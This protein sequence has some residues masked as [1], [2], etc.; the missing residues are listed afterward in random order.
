MN[1]CS[2]I[3]RNP[4]DWMMNPYSFIPKNPKSQKMNPCSFIPK[5][6]KSRMMNPCSFIPRKPGIIRIYG[7]DHR[8]DQRPRKNPNI[9]SFEISSG[10]STPI[11]PIYRILVDLD[12]HHVSLK[13]DHPYSFGTPPSYHK[14]L[15]DDLGLIHRV[16]Q[17]FTYQDFTTSEDDRS[18]P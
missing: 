7:P 3:P 10:V 9:L 6:P 8:L 12:L 11:S 15:S 5:N 17:G 1:T 14:T 18:F 13:M 4:K 2:F 16:C